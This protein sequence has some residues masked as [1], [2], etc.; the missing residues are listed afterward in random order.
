MLTRRTFL[1]SVPAALVAATGKVS[2]QPEPTPEQ[3]AGYV[4][5]EYGSF[6]HTG[7]CL[8]GVSFKG[9]PVTCDAHQRLGVKYLGTITSF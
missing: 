8:C 2:A 9:V 5:K 1:V 4:W 3:P 7:P 6:T